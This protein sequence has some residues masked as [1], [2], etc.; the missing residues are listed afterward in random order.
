MTYFELILITFGS[1][2]CYTSDTLTALFHRLHYQ[3]LNRYYKYRLSLI[4]TARVCDLKIGV[5]FQWI[6]G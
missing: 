3:R 2:K 1:A 6:S 5:R 4:R